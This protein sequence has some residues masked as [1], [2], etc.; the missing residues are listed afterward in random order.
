MMAP[1][2]MARSVPTLLMLAALLI[3]SPK[4]A[5]A[6]Q[7]AVEEFQKG[8]AL[9]VSG[10]C[11]EAI[12]HFRSSLA[13]APAIGPLMNI[14]ECL[15]KLNKQASALKAYEQANELA[16]KMND[17]ERSAASEQAAAALRPTLSTITIRSSSSTGKATVDGQPQTFGQAVPQDGGDHVVIM[18]TKQGRKSQTTIHLGPSG[19][20]QAIDMPEDPIEPLMPPT[21]PPPVQSDTGRR[22]L[23]TPAFVIG[24]AGAVA[25]AVGS[26]LG[27]TVLSTRSELS[28][29]CTD[30]PSCPR[31]SQPE[32]ADLYNS[33]Q[34]RA[35][36]STVTLSIGAVAL[37]AGILLF[38]KSR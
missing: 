2:T 12:I 30:Y 27:I 4:P 26:V 29:L 11:E 15:T 28:D 1:A 14:G 16:K 35:T 21:Q 17:A 33:A 23:R 3:A 25:V 6:D 37:A 9:V 10:H 13:I 20:A 22:D 24:G 32:V 38:L 7:K 18:E 8:R 34:T 31:A 5:H 36:I 19:D